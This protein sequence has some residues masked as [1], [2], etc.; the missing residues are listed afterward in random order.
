MG[1]WRQF[2]VA[3]IK[4]LNSTR[5]R[6]RYR[7]LGRTGWQVSDIGAGMWGWPPGRAM[8]KT[9]SARPCNWRLSWVVTFSIQPGGMGLVPARRF[10]ANWC[11]PT[12]TKK[13]YTASKIPPKNFVWPSHRGDPLS[14]SYPADHIRE[15]TEK[16]L[17]NMGVDS[18]DLMQFHVWE[19]AWAMIRMA[20]GH[21]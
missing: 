9:R 11:G 18:I 12:L 2:P 19:D 10:W 1:H 21:Q 7:T 4:E 8:T 17:A 6:M 3:P 20:K 14:G 15:Y 13:L 16:S 5:R